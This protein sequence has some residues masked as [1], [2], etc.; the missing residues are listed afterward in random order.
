MSARFSSVVRTALVALVV[1]GGITALQ[2]RQPAEAATGNLVQNNAV[3]QFDS[4]GKAVGW[5]D[6]SY[7]TSTRTLGVTAPGR[8]GAGHALS[9]SVT[10]FS[11]GAVYFSSASFPV[12][13][14][15]LYTVSDWYRSTV[16]SEINAKVT[17]S[18]GT[19][20]YHLVATVP[21]SADWAQA[22]GSFTAPAGALSVQ[23]YHLIKGAG[24]LVTD[25]YGAY[26]DTGLDRGMVSVTFDDGWLTQYDVARPVLA[27]NGIPGTFYIVSGELRNPERMTPQQILQLRADGHEI[28]A[29]SISHPDLSALGPADVDLQLAQ[30][31]R[32]LEALLGAPVR[33][34]A[35]PFGSA[36][37]A[38]Q[39]ACLAYYRT[40]R[41][42]AWGYNTVGYDRGAVTVQY[43]HPTTTP[44]QF[45]SW[46]DAARATRTWLVLVYHSFEATPQKVDDTT[47]Q[48]FADQMAYLR[49]S[50]VPTRTVDDAVTLLAQ[51][52]D[53]AA[54]RTAVTGPTNGGTVSAGPVTVTASATDDHA[55]TAVDLL[56]D[57]VPVQ[58]DGT[59]PYA[60][61]WTATSGRHT[62]QTRAHDAAGHTGTSAPV[63]VDALTELATETWSGTAWPAGW[64]TE[65]SNGHVDVSAGAGRL[66][67]DDVRYAYADARLDGAAGTDTDLVLSYRFGQITGGG[68]FTVFLRGS[69]GWQD[70][71]R[72]RTGYGVELS[73]GSGT[74]TVEKSVDG[75][76]TDL[77]TVTGARPSTTGKQWLRLRITGDQLRFRVW[78]DGTAEPA[79]WSA[80]VTDGAVTGPGALYLAFARSS[81][82]T[83]AKHVTLDDLVL[84]A[85][86]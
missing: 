8:L 37:P 68:W 9:V 13:A 60:F 85:A 20:S 72:P 57:G 74:V 40:C 56:V 4:A 45:R 29:H 24:T 76:V 66:A 17:R 30:S 83:G 49:S 19:A 51:D 73:S 81:T 47:P 41:T 12:T 52:P 44:A 5:T 7:G 39:A 1:L 86:G 77:R 32:D 14:G 46:V 53:T 54:P 84:R 64:S 34:F 59:A 33:N 23:I 63:T 48:A 22:A 6:R 31:Q 18:T 35:Y 50:G 82:N 78:P 71:F 75:T 61:G 42:T 15:K 11:D 79:T 58:S 65:V 21:A 70:G 25:D 16:P 36:N 38:V 67:F 55:V 69:G 43:I 27:A 26:T 10:A 3:D 2:A 80:T 62:V 28:G